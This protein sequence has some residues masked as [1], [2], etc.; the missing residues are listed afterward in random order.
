MVLLGVILVPIAS[1]KVSFESTMMLFVSTELAEMN[2]TTMF[3]A[4]V[5][6][7]V[8]TVDS[9]CVLTFAVKPSSRATESSTSVSS[10][11]ESVLCYRLYT[12]FNGF[13]DVC[14]GAYTSLI[15][16]VHRGDHFVEVHVGKC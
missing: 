16:G 7:F 11:A 10:T 8:A 13:H 12:V 15:F 1:V 14:F 9:S 2:K 4:I 5:T 6:H 3:F